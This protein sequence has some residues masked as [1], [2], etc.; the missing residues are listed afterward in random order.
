MADRF[1]VG[2]IMNPIAGLGGPSGLKG[3]D[4]AEQIKTLLSKVP[5]HETRS[6]QRAVETFSKLPLAGGVVVTAPGILGAEA[7]KETIAR[8]GPVI[9]VVRLGIA[10]KGYGQSTAEDTRLFAAALVE[11]EIDI[12]VFAG[13]DGTA[14]DVAEAVA[15]RVPILGIPTGVKMLS[16]VFAQSPAMAREILRSLKKGFATREVEVIDLE[17]SSYQDGSFIVRAHTTA[18]TPE[19]PGI[20]AG[21]DAGAATEA[22]G[23]LDLAQWFEGT[24]EPEG[25][26]ILG[27]GTTTK[28]LKQVL[29]E[30]TPLGVDAYVGRRLVA[31]D[32]GEEALLALLDSHSSAR[33][34]V[35]PT[36]GQGCVLG[37]GTAQ[38]SARVVERVGVSSVQVV[39]TPAKLVGIHE[40]FV[41]TGDAAL[42]A[43][44]PEFIKVRTDPFTEKMM[45]LRRGA[46]RP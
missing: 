38:I 39:A 14:I 30:G 15:G 22:E 32:A 13:G 11:R 7:L 5:F 26:M 8:M 33:I 29:G 45:R 34:I 36:G 19:T 16:G 40:L 31:K 2:F 35:S 41:D 28:A 23:L 37:R 43:A 44:F 42:D 18:R 25:L 6:F 20:P 27:A 3:S 24:L 17:E 12:L 10:G 9:E 4:D 1:R 21:K 46:A